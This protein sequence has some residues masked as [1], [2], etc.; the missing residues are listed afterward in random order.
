M[1]Q[2][3]YIK[4]GTTD[5]KIGKNIGNAD[6][7]RRNVLAILFQLELTFYGMIRAKVELFSIA[8]RTG[9]WW[10]IGFYTIKCKIK[11]PIAI[12]TKIVTRKSNT[13][14]LIDGV[15]LMAGK[16]SFQHCFTLILPK[17][18]ESC[19]CQYNRKLF[20]RSLSFP[21]PPHSNTVFFSR[22]QLTETRTQML[23]PRATTG[24]VNR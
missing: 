14:T 16:F 11:G 4:N 24:Y 2:T 8:A 18:D 10:G 1:L 3:Q 20:A 9:A 15:S 7:I 17:Y 13:L 12:G 6:K 23:T 22:R 19:I 5:Y 21:A